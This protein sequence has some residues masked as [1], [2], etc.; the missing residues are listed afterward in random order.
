MILMAAAGNLSSARLNAAALRKVSPIEHLLELDGD[1][2]S[3]VESVDIAELVETLVSA[4]RCRF[5]INTVARAAMTVLPPI[6]ANRVQLRQA[7]GNILLNAAQATLSCI[8]QP[9]TITV[10]SRADAGDA[11][12]DIVDTGVGIAPDDLPRIFDPFFSTKPTGTA[13]GLGLSLALAIAKS[14]AGDIQVKSVLGRGTTVSVRLS[15]TLTSVSGK[16]RLPAARARILLVE[17]DDGVRYA[18]QRLLQPHHEVFTELNALAALDRLWAHREVDL[19][20]YDLASPGADALEFCEAVSLVKPVLG[21][22]FVF[23]T[24]GLMFAERDRLLLATYPGLL[25]CK[26]FSNEHL[27]Q[28]IAIQLH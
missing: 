13:L 5:G 7:F 23:L 27:R 24:G 4:S 11:I 8:A 3:H 21:D 12:V 28:A 20:V 25:L 15:C 10:T 18:I 16:R 26:P 22:R 6:R 1:T 9:T 14:A 19:I 2:Q 17:Q